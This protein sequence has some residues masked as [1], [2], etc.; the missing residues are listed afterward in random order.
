MGSASSDETGIRRRFTSADDRSVAVSS[1]RIWL[2]VLLASIFAAPIAG[3]EDLNCLEGTTLSERSDEGVRDAWCARPDGVLH[4]PYRSWHPNGQLR[5]AT[6]YVDGVE[7]G[8]LRAWHPSGGR[9]L[10]ARLAHAKLEGEWRE[11]HPNG[12]LSVR[13]N[14]EAGD[15]RGLATWWYESG[16]KR[17]EGRFEGFANEGVWTTW[18]QNGK[19]RRECHWQGGVLEGACR[20]WD[21]QG[22]ERFAVRYVASVGAEQ[23]SYWRSNGELEGFEIQ[24]AWM[25]LDAQA[26]PASA[27]E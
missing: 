21:E 14:F 8:T 3:A 25:P 7:H 13:A 10:E 27:G 2:H 6:Q 4:G 16:A 23:W 17:L 18:W 11:W 1:N 15:P 5:S 24:S 19:R 22:G 9:A 12:Q 20:S 26:L